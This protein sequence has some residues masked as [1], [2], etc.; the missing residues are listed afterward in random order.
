[1]TAPETG[2]IVTEPVRK[3]GI[4]TLTTTLTDTG[5]KKTILGHNARHIK[6]T[7]VREPSEDACDQKREK[8]ETDGWYID[9]KV[10]SLASSLDNPAAAAKPTGCNDEVRHK[11]AGKGKLG[12]PVQYTLTNYGQDG[13]VVSSLSMEVVELS[14]NPLEAALFEAPAGYAQA[15]DMEEMTR[16]THLASAAAQPI[17]QSSIQTGNYVTN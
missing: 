3:G 5:E 12:Y 4:A 14:A 8:I 16:M 13:N 15:H 10:E 7:L 9:L 11:Q 1:M 6:T 17:I 2:A